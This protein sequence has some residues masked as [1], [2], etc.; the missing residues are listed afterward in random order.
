[1]IVAVGVTGVPS[2]TI[3]LTD[4]QYSY[5]LDTKD[6]EE[7]VAERVRAILEAGI[8]HEEDAAEVE[9]GLIDE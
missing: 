3:H 2:K 9:S 7:S 6:D 4:E 5:V 1:M 8:Q